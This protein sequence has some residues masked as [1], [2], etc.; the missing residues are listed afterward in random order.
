M[1]AR[2]ELT[3]YSQ[4]P[5]VSACAATG[6][7]ENSS[8]TVQKRSSVL[9]IR[10]LI[11]RSSCIRNIHFHYRLFPQ[12]KQ[13][14]YTICGQSAKRQKGARPVLTLRIR[15]LRSSKGPC[16]CQTAYPISIEVCHPQPMASPWP[17][18][19]KTAILQ[20]R[21][22]CSLPSESAHPI[23]ASQNLQFLIASTGQ[24]CYHGGTTVRKT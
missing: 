13:E 18:I 6:R 7:R 4:S 5:S 11:N 14:N 9:V 16:P 2:P 23:T 1:V 17:P 21:L 22:L 19:P 3:E 15:T 8:N 20:L 12:K 24:I 10:F